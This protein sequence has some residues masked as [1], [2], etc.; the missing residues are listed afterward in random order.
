MGDAGSDFWA[1]IQGMDFLEF[2]EPPEPMVPTEPANPLGHCELPSWREAEDFLEFPE[3]PDLSQAPPFAGQQAGLE[4]AFNSG[5]GFGP[6]LMSWTKDGADCGTIPECKL[7]HTACKS[8]HR[9]KRRSEKFRLMTVDEMRQL[10]KSSSGLCPPGE[11]KRELIDL[12]EQHPSLLK[13]ELVHKLLQEK[14]KFIRD[15]AT[16]LQRPAQGIYGHFFTKLYRNPLP[17]FSPV[18]RLTVSLIQKQLLQKLI[19]PKED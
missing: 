6:K 14:D 15:M 17:P 7:G 10:A 1:G 2:S 4:A 13:W 18:P 11:W 19:P 16:Q 3:F 9:G 12:R 8:N 5:P